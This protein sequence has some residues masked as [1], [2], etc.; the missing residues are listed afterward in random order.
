MSRVK[1][2]VRKRLSASGWRATGRGASCQPAVTVPGPGRVRASDCG[3]V[4]ACGQLPVPK[5]SA[6]SDRKHGTFLCTLTWLGE[7]GMEGA[8][9]W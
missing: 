8:V 5:P 1:V 2:T 4:C 3:Y 7:I 6:E 9:T